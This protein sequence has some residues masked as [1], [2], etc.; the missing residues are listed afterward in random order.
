[1][2]T[3]NGLGENQNVK[4]LIVA[5][6]TMDSFLMAGLRWEELISML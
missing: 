4:K 5:D 3:A 6:Q 1:M 2:R